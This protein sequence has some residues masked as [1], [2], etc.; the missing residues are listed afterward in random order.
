M[1]A[2]GN[3]H[4]ISSTFVRSIGI[5]LQYMSAGAGSVRA[6][7]PSIGELSK[8]E[9]Y[10]SFREADMMGFGILPGYGGLQIPIYKMGTIDEVCATMDILDPTRKA[11][12]RIRDVRGIEPRCT[13]GF[14]D[15]ISLSAPMLH[16]T[17]SSIIR[18]PVLT[19]YCV[20]LTSHQEGFVV[21]HNRLKEYMTETEHVISDQAKW[22]LQQY[23]TLKAHYPEWENEGLA[24][25]QVNDR[26]QDFLNDSHACWDAATEYFVDLQRTENLRYQDLMASHVTQAVNYWGD[27]WARIKEGKARNHYGLRPLV[28]E[29]M[30]MYWDYLPNIVVAMRS[31]GFRGEEG[32][33][34]EAWFTMMFRAFCWWRCHFMNPG[35]N[36]V[37]APMRL[38]SRYWDSELPVYIE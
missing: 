2:E 36:M 15:I 10:V 31:K 16:T 9:L 38:P 12:R 25:D 37:Q 13:F 20:G 23:E 5:I 4:V 35:E 19:E 22:V 29:G 26:S 27:A 30:H 7:W 6:S 3:G 1:R 8:S 34:H 14:S 33:V 24:N 11:S 28:A 17:G 32:L 18:L 21:F